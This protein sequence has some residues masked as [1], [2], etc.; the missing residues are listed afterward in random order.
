LHC[1]LSH[2]IGEDK[3][4]CRQEETLQR[5]HRHLLFRH[6]ERRVLRAVQRFF[7]SPPPLSLPLSLSVSL[8]PALP[9]TGCSHAWAGLSPALVVVIPS[10]ALSYASYGTLKSYILHHKTPLLYNPS[11]EQLTVIGGLVC[12]SASGQSPSCLVCSSHR[13]ALR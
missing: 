13:P 12:G 10:I 9:L 2:R 1:L 8:L 5:H 3:T 11:T 7:A 4:D 6:Q